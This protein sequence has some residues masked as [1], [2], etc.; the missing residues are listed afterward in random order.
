M[1]AVNSQTRTL[2]LDREITLPSSG[3][4]LIT[5][6]TG[7]VIRSA[8]RFQ[9]VTDGVK[10][11]VSRVPDGVGIQRVG[12]KLPTL[13]QRLFRCVSI[14]EKND[15]GTYAITAVQHVPE[16]KPSWITGAL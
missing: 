2:T 8:W 16:K 10:V 11:K 3:T 4:T 15:D 13:R 6:L 1:L 12:L 5:W 9:S 14:R 7:R